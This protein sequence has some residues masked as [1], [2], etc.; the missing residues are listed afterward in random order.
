MFFH[1]TYASSSKCLV[2]VI[3]VLKIHGDSH[4]MLSLYIAQLYIDLFKNR[5]VIFMQNASV[6]FQLLVK[7][8]YRN[9]INS[10]SDCEQEKS[11]NIS[12]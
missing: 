5:Y 8:T 3:F 12:D 1:K 2:E 10:L 11:K 6:L 4:I 9:D 7:K